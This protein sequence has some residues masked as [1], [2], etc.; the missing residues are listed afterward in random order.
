MI[1]ALFGIQNPAYDGAFLFLIIFSNDHFFFNSY[2]N[3][4]DLLFVNT[5]GTSS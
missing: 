5:L 4:T 1:E 2:L 3:S